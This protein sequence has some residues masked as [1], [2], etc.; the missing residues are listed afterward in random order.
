MLAKDFDKA[1]RRFTEA[2]YEV[3]HWK[4][5]FMGAAYSTRLHTA[6]EVAK[7]EIAAM[8]AVLEEDEKH[9]QFDA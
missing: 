7:Q 2:M 1:T 8:E 5:N 3:A 4:E 9:D 6:I